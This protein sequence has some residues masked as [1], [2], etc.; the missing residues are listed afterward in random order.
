[1]LFLGIDA[2][3]TKT[4]ALVAD[5][6]GAVRGVGRAGPGNWEDVGLVEAL[7]TLQ[8]AITEA[9]AQ[10]DASP[11]EVTAAAY[12]LAGL[13]WPSDEERLRPLVAQLGVAGPQIL[14]NDSLVAL[15]VGARGPW[16]VVI[17]AGTGTT[18]AGRNREGE[19]ARTL[20]LGYPFDDWG[21]APDLAGA[22]VHAVA[23]AYTGRGPVTSLTGRL[24]RQ[25]DAHDAADLREGLSRRQYHLQPAVAEI[26]QALFREAQAG[27]A[28]AQGIV[29]RAGR[30]LG[31]GAVA[32]IRRLR[33]E[34][35]TFDLVLSGGVFRS[36]SPLLLDALRETVLA[37]A[38]GGR[39][40]LL[41]APPVVGA[42]LLAMEQTG[43][44]PAAVREALIE[45]TSEL[46]RK[47]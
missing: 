33:M 17:I 27:D 2:G 20:G 30:K 13:D 14:V 40:V 25:I 28:A 35:E 44:K 34:K 36:P 46:L 9:L 21:S 26:V 10:A 24:V 22:C 31:G 7:N 16:G 29:R 4:H 8:Q 3:G 38:P 23:R 5:R 12:G 45:S 39:P 1:M 41:E 15:R 42:V 37:V 47:N 32:V 6:A 43:M 11:S 18:V 19:T